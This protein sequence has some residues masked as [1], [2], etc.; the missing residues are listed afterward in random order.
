[1]AIQQATLTIA[2]NGNTSGAMELKGG[3]SNIG[4]QIPLIDTAVV[5]VLVSNDNST[6]QT[7]SQ[8]DDAT[9]LYVASGTGQL[10]WTVKAVRPWRWL[11]IKTSANQTTRAVNFIVSANE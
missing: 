2:Q 8:E 1:M 7:L 10:A 6:Y 5:T 3:V 9:T 11:K 4:I